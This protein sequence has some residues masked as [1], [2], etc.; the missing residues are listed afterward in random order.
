[1]APE[2]S[3][4]IS[5]FLLWEK[6]V[7]TLTPAGVVVFDRGKDGGMK[8]GEGGGDSISD[9]GEAGDSGAAGECD[10][11]ESGVP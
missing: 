9:C 11:G 4:I 1:M 8:G 6:G 10:F 5:R 7:I 2:S 3:A